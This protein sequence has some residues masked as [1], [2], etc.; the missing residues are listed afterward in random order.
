MFQEDWWCQSQ[1]SKILKATFYSAVLNISCNFLSIPLFHQNGAAW[2]TVLAE[3]L[4]AFY[5]LKASGF[6]LLTYWHFYLKL[7]LATAIMGGAVA[8]LLMT[9]STTV[10]LLLLS[11]VIGCIV[12]VVLSYAFNVEAIHEFLVKLKMKLL[13]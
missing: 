3:L 13:R 1:E 4:V 6:K 9:I 11:S 7:L 12:Y 8:G 10:L 5:L 2:T